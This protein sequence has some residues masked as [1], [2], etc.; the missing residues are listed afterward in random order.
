MGPEAISLPYLPLP[1]ERQREERRGKEKKILEMVPWRAVALAL[2]LLC[3]LTVVAI[4]RHDINLQVSQTERQEE[5]YKEDLQE[6]YK[7]R[8]GC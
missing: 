1:D 3:L 2:T 5:Q 8:R 4:N 6:L 7:V